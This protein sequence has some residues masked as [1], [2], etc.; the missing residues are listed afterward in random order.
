MAFFTLAPGSPSLAT[1]RIAVPA[2]PWGPMRCA[3]PGDVLMV[4]FGTGAIPIVL[5]RA[6]FLGLQ[7]QPVADV[8]DALAFRAGGISVAFSLAPGSPTL[9]GCS[10]PVVGCTAIS[11]LLELASKSCTSASAVGPV[12]FTHV[13]PKS[14]ER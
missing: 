13:A 5:R 2:G 4:P 1:C 11:M 12:I 14:S 6:E 7:A 9:G 10:P 8:I 3:T